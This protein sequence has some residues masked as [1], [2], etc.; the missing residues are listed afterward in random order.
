MAVRASTKS[1]RDCY[2]RPA[3]GDDKTRRAKA[4]CYNGARRKKKMPNECGWIL[5]ENRYVRANNECEGT[6]RLPVIIG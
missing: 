1:E 5:L 2:F 4:D 6:K 3:L